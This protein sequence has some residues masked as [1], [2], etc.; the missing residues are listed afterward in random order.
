MSIL[1]LLGILVVFL[2]WSV[3]ACA[4]CPMQEATVFYV[5]G[6]DADIKSSE[7]SRSK[8]EKELFVRFSLNPECVLVK[9]A[10]NASATLLPDL[11]EAAVQK[12]QEINTELSTFWKLYLRAFSASVGDALWFTAMVRTAYLGIDVTQ[13]V[14]QEQLGRH[15]ELYRSELAAGRQVILV[16]HSQGNLYANAAW[17]ELTP[18]ERKRV[19][20]VSVATPSDM[21]ADGGPYT[22]LAE[23]GAAQWFPFA[24]P[25]NAANGE[26]CPDPWYCHGFR[27]WYLFGSNSRDRIVDRIVELLPQPSITGSIQGTLHMP[28]GSSVNQAVVWLY[29]SYG[30]FLDRFVVGPS[31]S[32]FF[33]GVDPCDCVLYAALGYWST[34]HTV[35]VSAGQ[36]TGVSVT[37]DHLAIPM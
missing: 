33:E 30:D 17:N 3:H 20:I 37:L 31:G 29:D 18:D 12:T 4:Q 27:E 22:T 7:A 28:D 6:V 35:H 5:N 26:P 14:I 24:L 34:T 19:H 15:M 23:D 9:R 32:F 11:V 16:P 36:T 2:V 8:L 25:A 21:V 1:R 10:Y 13:F